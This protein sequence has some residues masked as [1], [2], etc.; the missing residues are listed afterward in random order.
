MNE[1]DQVNL[2][3]PEQIRVNCNKGWVTVYLSGDNP[4]KDGT[5]IYRSAAND[6][7]KVEVL[8]DPSHK[9]VWP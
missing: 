8:I 3:L 6:I 7:A 9:A 2:H 1:A 5:V 4:Q